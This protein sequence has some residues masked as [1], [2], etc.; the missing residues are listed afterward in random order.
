M[1]TAAISA[2][3]IDPTAPATY[4]IRLGDSIVKAG[5]SARSWASVRYNH[6]PVP[7]DREQATCSIGSAGSKD[8]SELVLKAG[9]NEYGYT[10]DSTSTEHEYILVLRGA[11]EN[12][13]AVLEEL[14]WRHAF[15]LTSTPEEKDAEKLRERYPQL[16]L[17]HDTNASRLDDNNNTTIA[18]APADPDNP[19]DYR[20]FLKAAAAAPK[21]RR[22]DTG[23]L[24]RSGTAT[25]ALHSRAA[26]S[27]P[28]PRPLK[29]TADSALVLPQKKRKVPPPPSTATAAAGGDRAASAKRVKAGDERGTGPPK[30]RVDRKA[31]SSSSVR[32]PS[33]NDDDVD[34]GELILENEEPSKRRHVSGR[35]RSAMAMALTG[36][37]GKGQGPISLRSAASS[38][39]VYGVS[40]GPEGLKI[41]VA[42]SSPEET[43]GR[44]FSSRRRKSGGAGS[45]EDDDDDDGNEEDEI[46]EEEEE[47]DGDDEDADVEDLELPSPATRAHKLSIS[48]ATATVTSTVT[49]SAGA[50]EED[51]LD[52]QLAAAMAEEEEEEESEEE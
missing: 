40:L 50:G 25:P 13:E 44:A 38:P 34:S 5:D 9:G 47:D 43:T 48:G 17:E 16:T 49:G 30:I 42:E 27:T 19:F 6:K 33:H 20:H 8:G 12:K 22:P 11:G 23:V 32:R 14:G 2:P 3:L 45:P 10:G 24:P 37:L 4:N 31:S 26:S 39:G 51:D 21:S 41:G 36:Q 35:G 29:R 18:E 7:T 15:N 52:A 28:L 46:V 1:A